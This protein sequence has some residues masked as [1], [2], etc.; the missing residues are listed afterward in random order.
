MFDATIIIHATDIYKP[1]DQERLAD[2]IA[3]S[4]HVLAPEPEIR[5]SAVA[6]LEILRTQRKKSDALLSLLQRVNVAEVTADI[7]YRA[8]EIIDAM[9]A[10]KKVCVHCL[11]PS[12]E[13]VLCKQCGRTVAPAARVNDAIIVATAELTPGVTRLYT[14]DGGLLSLPEHARLGLRVEV[15]EPTSGELWRHAASRRPPPSDADD[16]SKQR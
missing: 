4:Q 16:E 3:A 13:G 15:E 9:V 6:L 1:K 10:S 12:G 8:A 7:A 2:K 5:L 11:A 14:F